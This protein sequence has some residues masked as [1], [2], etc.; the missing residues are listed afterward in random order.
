MNVTQDTHLKKKL[1]TKK[2]KQLK[3]KEGE[4][5]QRDTHRQEEEAEVDSNEGEQEN[6]GHR[7][8][9]SSALIPPKKGKT[10]RKIRVKEETQDKPNSPGNDEKAQK[11]WN[12]LLMM[13]NFWRLK[14]GVKKIK[15][16]FH[17]ITGGEKKKK[18]IVK[19]KRK[20]K[21]NTEEMSGVYTQPVDLSTTFGES[22]PLPPSLNWTH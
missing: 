4:G 18:K 9:A 11:G 13:N 3:V 20:N 10:R 21:I 8:K 14:K 12:L 2:G 5:D 7:E 6:S 15:Y 17:A 16:F 1:K 19:V 22:H